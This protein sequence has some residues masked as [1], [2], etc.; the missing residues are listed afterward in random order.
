MNRPAEISG[1]AGS[2]VLVTGASGGLGEALCEMLA[3]NGAL[4][5]AGARRADK[6]EEL[7]ARIH[8]RGGQA[9]ACPMDVTDEQSV[10]AAWDVAERELGPVSGVIANAGITIDGLA[11]DLSPASFRT[12]IDTN[13]TGVFLTLR[14]GARRMVGRRAEGRMIAIASVLADKVVP[15]IAPYAASKAAVVQLV[16]ALALEWAARGISVNAISPGY[17]R[18][19][20]NQAFM[21]SRA[22]ERF[23]AGFP[24]QRL[25]QPTDILPLAQLLLS[26]AARTIT[27]RNFVV[28]DGQTL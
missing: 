21:D 11:L 20:I 23:V 10:A 25:L 7:V 26:D 24:R 15:G 2:T 22:G 5:A 8:A 16:R 9:C 28:D 18:T 13:L 3:A 14:E 1:I 27:G 17:I 4:V 6:V 19:D 12:V